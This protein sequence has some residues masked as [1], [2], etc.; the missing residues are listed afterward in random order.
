[1]IHFPVNHFNF[2]S[3]SLIF[4]NPFSIFSMLLAKEIRI[5]LGSSKALPV[6]VETYAL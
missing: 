3:A 2:K 4:A 6:T 5:Q 1:M